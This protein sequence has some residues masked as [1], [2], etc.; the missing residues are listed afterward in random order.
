MD[1]HEIDEALAR[2]RD[3]QAMVMERRR[4]RGY[5]GLGRFAGG[6]LA[7]VASGI[8]CHA[9]WV[10]PTRRA[11]LAGWMVVLAAGLALNYAPLLAWMLR[12]RRAHGNWNDARPA[13]HA[14][15]ALVVGAAL[16]LAL[17]RA[18]AH[19]LLFGSWM[20]VFGLVHG[21]YRRLLPPAILHLGPSYVACGA[22]YLVAPG[23]DFL[24]PRP[25]G[26]V[27]GLGEMLGGICLFLDKP[28]AAAP[29]R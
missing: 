21:A 24:D 20:S 29:A 7:L 12:Q 27:F 28:L 2:V 26:L 1:G 13:A 4:F 15:P 16:T 5:S 22:F 23:I 14:L 10:A 6:A 25:M 8:L 11:H 19:D 9:Q 18:N 3:M 17:V